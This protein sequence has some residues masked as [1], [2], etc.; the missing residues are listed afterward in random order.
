M[1][2]AMSAFTIRSKALFMSNKVKIVAAKFSIL[3]GSKRTKQEET[4]REIGRRAGLVFV[5]SY[6][7]R[8]P[9]VKVTKKRH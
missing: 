2:R 8:P 6:M 3:E 9:R 7:R 4:T 5:R 1:V